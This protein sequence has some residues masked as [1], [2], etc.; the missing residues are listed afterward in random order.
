MEMLW[1]LLWILSPLGLVYTFEIA[2]WA[3]PGTD[4]TSPRKTNATGASEDFIK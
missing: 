3:A 2:S 4:Q 1:V